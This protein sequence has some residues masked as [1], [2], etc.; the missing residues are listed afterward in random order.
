MKKTLLIVAL[1]AGIFAC[2]SPAKHDDKA[3]ADAVPEKKA[4]SPMDNPDYD[5]GLALVAKSDC[6]TCHKLNEAST[7]PAYTAVAAKYPS[8]DSTYNLLAD[9]IIKG[10]TGV[11]GAAPMSPHPT[12]SH[13]DAVQMVKYIMLL[14]E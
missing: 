1:A 4:P 6:F 8:T 5:K 3:A 10:G 11:W 9:K 2:S 12:V 7:G 13:E 14:K